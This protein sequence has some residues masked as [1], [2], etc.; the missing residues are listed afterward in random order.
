MAPSS[1]PLPPPDWRAA[2]A[3]RP[4][5]R[6]AGLLLGLCLAAGT[7]AW[8]GAPGTHSSAAP[9]KPPAGSQPQRAASKPVW[10]QLTV[11][12]QQALAPLRPAWARLSESRKRKWIALARNFNDLTPLEQAKLHSRMTEWVALSPQQRAQA[13]LNFGESKQMSEQDKRA[14]WDAYRALPDNERRKLAAGAPPR[15]PP[16]AVAV[17]PVPANKLAPLPRA[18]SELRAARIEAPAPPAAH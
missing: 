8:A 16:T 1:S 17:R 6:L 2:A 3:A 15:T 18:G 14:A 11:G 4:G 10:A 5:Q 12:Q 13:R 7:A 9:A